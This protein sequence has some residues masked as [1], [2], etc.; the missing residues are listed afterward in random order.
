MDR[1]GEECPAKAGLYVC[2]SSALADNK[3]A[4]LAKESLKRS[5]EPLSKSQ[6]MN[7]EMRF[8]VMTQPETNEKE[9]EHA[10]N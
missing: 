5:P 8:A 10:E 1:K 4:W 3:L 6:V 9:N 2:G 7:A